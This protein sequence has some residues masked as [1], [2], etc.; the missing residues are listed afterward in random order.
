MIFRRFLVAALFVFL[1]AVLLAQVPA[2]FAFTRDS[3]WAQVGTQTQFI[4]T[5][6]DAGAAQ[7]FTFNGSGTAAWVEAAGGATVGEAVPVTFSSGQTLVALTVPDTLGALRLRVT[8]DGVSSVS[9]AVQPF[10]VAAVAAAALTADAT[11]G[12]LLFTAG[13]NAAGNLANALVALDPLTGVLTPSAALG[14]APQSLAVSDDGAFAYVGLGF[15]NQVV[16]Y[17]LNAQAVVRTLTLGALGAPFDSY[18]YY[19]VDLAVV[20]GAPDTV[21][22]GQRTQESSFAT[23]VSYRNGVLVA[24]QSNPPLLELAAAQRSGVVYG[25]NTSNDGHDFAALTVSAGA[26]A[27]QPAADTPFKGFQTKLA[28]SGDLVIASTGVVAD[29]LALRGRGWLALPT[30][31]T[32]WAVGADAAA[33][34]FYAAQSPGGLWVFDAVTLRPLAQLALPTGLGEIAELQRWGADG[35]ALRLF[36]GD[37][38]VFRHPALAPTA[39]EADV[40]VAFAP[41][42][43]DELTPGVPQEFTLTVTNHGPNPAPAVRLDFWNDYAMAIAPGVTPGVT[44]ETLA[45]AVVARL[46]DLA[47]GE[48][49]VLTFALTA[50]AYGPAVLR[51]AVFSGAV[52]PVPENDGATRAVSAVFADEP[53]AVNALLL[54]A[55]DVVAH[56]VLPRVYVSTGSQGAPDFAQR[57]LELD[58]RT[59]RVLR[60]LETGGNPRRLAISDGGEFLYV[61]LGDETK[62]LRVDLVDF[63]VA[64]EI[65]MP[66]SA[67]GTFPAADIVVLPGQPGSIAVAMSYRGVYVFDGATARIASLGLFTGDRLE[68]G[69]DADTLLA[70]DT[71]GTQQLMRLAVFPSGLSAGPTYAAFNVSA[72]DFVSSGN[73]ALS[74]SGVVFDAKAGNTLG[75]I[76]ELASGAGGVPVLETVRGRAYGVV[77]AALRSYELVNFSRVGEVALPVSTHPP[78]KLIRW[79]DDG[80]VLLQGS[81]VVTPG[82]PLNGRLVFVRSSAL[83]PAAPQITSARTAQAQVGQS[84]SYVIEATGAP[85]TFA[86]APLPDGLNFN[87]E[88]GFISGTPTVAGT[89]EITLGAANTIGTGTATLVLTITPDFATWRAAAFLPGELDLETISGAEADPD[90]DGLAN[91]IEYALGTDPRAADAAALAPQVALGAEAWTFTFTKPVG[92]ADLSYTVQASSDLVEWGMDAIV[93]TLLGT[94]GG[95]EVWQATLPRGAATAMFFRLQVSVNIVAG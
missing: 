94:E 34:R 58:A 76:A 26:L 63:A 35:V 57:V 25:Y 15:S 5:A 88:T 3:E 90:A 86:A 19:P 85:D 33:R 77:N 75:T 17:D 4:V 55:T 6:R 62:V 31:V 28:A 12:R 80:F 92:R 56:P 2:D 73:L 46:G 66:A 29:G 43:G 50:A 22:V 79:G 27:V 89:F 21:L 60:A 54:H 16:Q 30:D 61:G 69:P 13:P 48:T 71:V 36:A 68:R 1:P 49:R 64:L 82:A 47:A 83:V 11:R 40:A 37:V 44:F 14:N 8:V 23:V 70:L 84:F 9:A 78:L 74:A 93:L 41:G 91:L 38:V 45:G 20:P 51:A 72:G 95:Y 53:E 67:Y 87:P 52:D 24:Q 42:T 65:P 18:A 39:P 32:A 7:L 59:G 81:N 10:R